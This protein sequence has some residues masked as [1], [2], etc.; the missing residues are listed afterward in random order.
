MKCARLLVTLFLITGLTGLCGCSFFRRKVTVESPPNPFVQ[1]GKIVNTKKLSKGGKLLIIPF[2]PG[3][4]V[5]ATSDMEKVAVMIVK[6][7][8]ETIMESDCPLEILVAHNA[9]TA[10][11]IIS[12][13]VVKMSSTKGMKKWMLNKRQRSLGVEG[14]LIDKKT[15]QVIMYFSH[16]RETSDSEESFE[17]IGLMIGKDIGKFILSGMQ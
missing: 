15:N 16:E 1:S 5:A 6:G 8:S 12:G 14:K 3:E 7:I 17:D 2:S 9:D 11:M 13:R 10:Q 4:D